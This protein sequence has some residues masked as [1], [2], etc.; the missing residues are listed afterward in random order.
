MA[1]WSMPGL[2]R[3]VLELVEGFF[4]T[5]W[6]NFFSSVFHPLH[7]PLVYSEY[8]YNQFKLFTTLCFCPLQLVVITQNFY[9]L[10]RKH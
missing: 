3:C 8:F 9:N 2:V 5:A 10:I 7:F 6:I 1:N 4:F